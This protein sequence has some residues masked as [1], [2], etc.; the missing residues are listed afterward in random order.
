MND[1]CINRM[2]IYLIEEPKDKALKLIED[3]QMEGER[4][5]K[6]LQ[7]SSSDSSSDGRF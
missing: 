7:K 2:Y 1:K 5:K 4:K 6:Y 3:E